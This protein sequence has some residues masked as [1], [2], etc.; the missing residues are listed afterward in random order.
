MEIARLPIELSDLI[1]SNE[2]ELD[3]QTVTQDMLTQT[4]QLYVVNPLSLRKPSP[5]TR[6]SPTRKAP[7]GAATP[8]PTSGG[9][10]STRKR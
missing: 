5:S 8:Y 6:H 2:V 3:T 4:V 10:G 1:L 9:A 7:R